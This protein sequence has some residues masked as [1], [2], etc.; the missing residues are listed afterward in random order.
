[1]KNNCQSGM[2]MRTHCHSVASPLTSIVVPTL[3]EAKN[4][5]PL[6]E[7]IGAA[8]VDQSYEV[9]I[10]DDLS[11]DGTSSLCVELG[12]R[13]PVTLW[14][15]QQPT[16]GLSG[17]V[18]HGFTC[19]RGELLVVMDADLQHP[20]EVLPLIIAP[21]QKD[22]ADFV[23]GSRYVTG[24]GIALKWGILRQVH[25]RMAMLLAKPLG[26]QVHDAMSGFFGLRKELYVNAIGLNPCGYKIGLELLCRCRPRRVKEVPI[27]FGARSQGSSKLNGIQ[28]LQYLRQ[29]AQLYWDT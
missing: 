9:L 28:Q 3:N 4:L 5:E 6:L 20:P 19:A 15:R 2:A 26:L 24:G 27:Q 11:Q 29:L 17:A 14:V 22:E 23:V 10:V 21:L 18:L 16:G 25:S 8:M 1:M 12:R 13:F 7:R